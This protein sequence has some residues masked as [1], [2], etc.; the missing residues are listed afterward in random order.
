V[1]QPVSS[2]QFEERPTL[3]TLTIAAFIF[4]TLIAIAACSGS[5]GSIP[6]TAAASQ[7]GSLSPVAPAGASTAVEM[8]DLAFNPASLTVPTGS[9]VTWTNNDTTAHTVTFDDASADSGALEPLSTFDHTFATAGTFAYHCNIHS[10][11]HGT[12]SVT[13]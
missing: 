5:A 7:A 4:M 9:K 2:V 1:A 13:P 11:M 12:V 3:R 8:K 6:S 10:F